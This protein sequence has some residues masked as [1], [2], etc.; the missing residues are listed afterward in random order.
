LLRAGFVAIPHRAGFRPAT[1]IY[2]SGYAV[3]A[4]VT[5]RKR[6]IE[7][8]A[9]L[10][11]SL[12]DALR[13]EGGGLELPAM[14]GAAQAPVARDRPGW[15][16]AVLRAAALPAQRPAATAAA[17]LALV[18]PPSRGGADYDLPRLLIEARA[19][20]GLPDFTG[21]LEVYHGTAPLVQATARPLAPGRFE[22]LR[23]QAVA[24]REGAATL[25]PLFDRD[26]WEVVGA[27]AA[28]PG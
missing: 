19:L 14:T 11:D 22:Q 7:L 12:A 17:Y 21:R 24:R 6:S 23:R 13:G 28:R 4:L 2:A 26:G 9:Y 20:D 16:A 8:A 10:T 15:G 25:A 3:P 27:V 1:V 18:A 5:R